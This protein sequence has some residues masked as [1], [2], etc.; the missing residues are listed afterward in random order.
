[1]KTISAANLAHL[2]SST[3]TLAVCWMVT[4]RDDV[5]IRGTQHNRDI[6]IDPGDSSGDSEYAGTYSALTGITGSDVRSTADMSVDNLEVEGA[7]AT[8]ALALLD[9]SAADIEAGLFD[10]AEVTTFVVNYE[11][12]NDGQIVMRTGTIGNITRTAE[13]QY[14]TELRGL[15]Q[16]LSQT[17]VRT[18]GTSCDADLFDSRCT[19]NRAAFT[20]NGTV[21]S[22]TNRR[23]FTAT[24]DYGSPDAEAGY[25]SGGR[26]TWVTGQN[27]DYTME[28]K[29]DSLDSPG[30]FL[31]FLPMPLDIEVGDTFTIEAACDKKKATCIAKFNNLV[32]FR[33][34]GVFV[35]GM[36]EV[37][38]IGGQ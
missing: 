30:D 31:L 2:Q 19:V 5:V 1:M 36:T 32:N 35:P 23:Q 4:R 27:T 17:I 10:D 37:L 6:T 20:F 34:H 25:F 26:V 13:G 22:V 3:T 11:A 38:K 18:Y 16:A 14:K 9:M 7:I 8:G 33:G 24:T 29:D 21:T 12:P 28:V 15:T